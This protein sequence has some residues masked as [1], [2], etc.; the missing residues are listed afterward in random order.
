MPLLGLLHNVLQVDN[1]RLELREG[2]DVLNEVVALLG[3]DLSR[4]AGRDLGLVDVV[5]C[6]VDA[7]SLP[8]LLHERVEPLIGCGHEVAPQQD[9]EVAGKLARRVCECCRRRGNVRR[10]SRLNSLFSRGASRQRCTRHRGP[11]N[12][13]EPAA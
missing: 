10:H 9:L 12:L 1:A 5:D 11:G 8:P 6:D 4:G 13:Q 7:D 3:L 2:G